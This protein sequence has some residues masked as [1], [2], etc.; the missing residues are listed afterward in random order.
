MNTTRQPA[1]GG[2]RILVVD[3]NVDAAETISMLLKIKGHQVHVRHS[4]QEGV[5]AAES[6][7]PEVVILD[8]SMPG[9]NGYDACR[10]I[11]EQPWGKRILVIAL[12]GFGQEEDIRL[13]REAGFD[14]HF[15]KPVDFA[16][17]TDLL[18]QL[19]NE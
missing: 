19:P 4:G 18:N 15:V 9:M 2:R 12:T 11:R 1:S 5:D 3:D 6:L 16:L 17:L 10:L 7:R 13:S 8:I 14:S